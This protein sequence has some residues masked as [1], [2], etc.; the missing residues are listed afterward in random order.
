MKRRRGGRKFVSDPYF[1][2]ANDSIA[3]LLKVYFADSSNTSVSAN[4]A[5]I[6]AVFIG[7]TGS[8]MA[9]GEPPIARSFRTTR[10]AGP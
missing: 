2:V 10:Y 8:S 6:E 3:A 7:G 9:S 4:K 1:M 5:D